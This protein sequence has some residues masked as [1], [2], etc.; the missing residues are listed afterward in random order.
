[1]RRYGPA[2]IAHRSDAASIAMKHHRPKAPIDIGSRLVMRQNLG[3]LNWVCIAEATCPSTR[4]R[5]VQRRDQSPAS[6]YSLSLRHTRLAAHPSNPA[7]EQDY[8]DR[9]P[10]R[11]HRNEPEHPMIVN[12]TITVLVNSTNPA[13]ADRRRAYRGLEEAP[14]MVCDKRHLPD[15]P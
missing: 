5:A 11:Q 7:T 12:N 1:M 2:T 6:S 9:P 10:S 15:R 14:P 13:I 8:K 3:G 4:L